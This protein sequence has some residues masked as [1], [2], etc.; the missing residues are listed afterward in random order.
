MKKL[1]TILLTTAFVFSSLPKAKLNAM[2]KDK[3]LHLEAG[4]LISGASFFIGP[5]LEKLVFDKPQIHP[6]LWGVGMSTLAGAGKELIYDKALGRGTP[7]LE[8][9]Y[10]TFIGGIGTSFALGILYEGLGFGSRDDYESINLNVNPKTKN[11][12][13]SYK[14]NFSL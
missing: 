2:P 1:V 14:F 6:M 12:S 13:L 4:I 7:E 9:F 11:F 10:Y 8:D 3:K 5:Q